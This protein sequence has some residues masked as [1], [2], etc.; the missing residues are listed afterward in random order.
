MNQMAN[1]FPLLLVLFWLVPL[2]AIAADPVAADSA[3]P[4]Q[5][6]ADDQTASDDEVEGLLVKLYKEKIFPEE[7]LRELYPR[8]V[9]FSSD[10]IWLMTYAID[11]KQWD[12]EKIVDML[13]KFE[14][15]AAMEIR[16]RIRV[17]NEDIDYMRKL[18]K[19]T[20]KS[21][22]FQLNLANQARQKMV[23]DRDYYRDRKLD[24]L[25]TFR[26]RN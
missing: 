16:I 25:P 10:K 8:F 19:A 17:A 26:V 20:E 14:A 23:A 7:K 6:T 1:V 12:A 22:A 5:Q 21:R 13:P 15:A 4:T 3:P 24:R 11:Y 18:A 2:Q 9:K